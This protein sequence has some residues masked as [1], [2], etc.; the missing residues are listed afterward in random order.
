MITVIAKI[1]AV[2]EEIGYV[3]AVIAAILLIP[4]A[5]LLRALIDIRAAA[6][7]SQVTH[8]HAKPVYS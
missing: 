6:Q 8:Q 2:T 3:L 1:K 4:F 7:H 5:L